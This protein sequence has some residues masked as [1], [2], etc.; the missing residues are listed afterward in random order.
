ML[1]HKRHDLILEKLNEEKSVKVAELTESLNVSVETI[2]R[3]LEYL[4][5]GGFLKRVHGGAVQENTI[6]SI[7][8]NFSVR[9]QK[10][11]EEKKIIAQTALN[12]VNEGQSIALDVSTTNTEF[13]KALVERFD[14][15]TVV[16]NSLPIAIILSKK[17]Y[18]TVILPGGSLRNEELC[19]VGEIAESSVSKFHIDTFFMSMSGISLSTGLTDYG[20]REVE[21]KKKMLAASQRAIIL[22]DHSKFGVVALLNVCDYKD[23][24]TIITDPKITDEMV[25]QYGRHDIK[26]DH[27][28]IDSSLKKTKE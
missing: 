6:S 3:D 16:T 11:I 25:E 17:P 15:L 2:R 4:E 27:H 12:Y 21:M 1:A 23:I 22:A 28:N 9:D 8:T 18:F 7:E 19:L 24:D 5:K 10:N 13:A 20:I 14:R 26:I